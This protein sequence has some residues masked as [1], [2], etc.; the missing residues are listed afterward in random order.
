MQKIAEP[1]YWSIGS[2]N[3][4]SEISEAPV[5]HICK[6][7]MPHSVEQNMSVTYGNILFEK[8]QKKKV[9]KFIQTIKKDKGYLDTKS[10]ELFEETKDAEEVLESYLSLIGNSN[11]ENYA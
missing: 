1:E 4:L 2:N 11:L 6:I 8:G 5:Q 10:L 7:Y 9:T 3:F